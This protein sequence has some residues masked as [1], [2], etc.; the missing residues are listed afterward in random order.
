MRCGFT[1]DHY[2][3]IL[4]IAKE[5]GYKF[6]GFD[7]KMPSDREKA[8]YL[9]HD[10]DLC[11]EEAIKMAEVEASFDIKSTYF[12]LINSC[13]YNILAKDCLEII[14]YLRSYDHHI[15]LHFDCMLM[16]WNARNEIDQGIEDIYSFLKNYIDLSP[17]VSFHRPQKEVINLTLQSL[18][19]TYEPYFFSDMKYIS[20]SRGQWRDGCICSIIK[21]ELFSKIQLLIHPVWWRFE[22]KSNLS[23]FNELMRKR[24]IAMENYISDNIRPLGDM[25]KNRKK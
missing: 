11:P 25:I 9:R 6:L 20:D 17:V 13:V 4:N 7:V 24:N 15:G 2:S 22:K 16:Q 10:I 21:N 23:I 1:L 12:F 14:E 19:S 3:E 18:T 8:I 5:K